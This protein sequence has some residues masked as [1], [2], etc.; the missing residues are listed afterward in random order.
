MDV[1]NL[2]QHFGSQAAAAR[3]VGVSAQLMS[4]WKKHGIPKGRQYEIQ[5]LTGGHLRASLARGVSRLGPKK[6]QRA[7]KNNLDSVKTISGC[8]IDSGSQ[9]GTGN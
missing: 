8:P 6:P 9:V 2:V 5:I 3:A 1:T 4:A 7:G